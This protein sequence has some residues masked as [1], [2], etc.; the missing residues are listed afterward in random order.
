MGFTYNLTSAASIFVSY[1]KNLSV[2]GTDAL[3]GS[4]F[5]GTSPEPETSDSFDAG[6]RYQA[7]TIQAQIAGFYNRYNNRLATAYDPVADLT[8]T[9]NLG[10]VDKYGVDGSI[11]WQPTQ[12][13]L[14]YVFGSY[15]KSEIKDDIQ[16]GANSFAPTAGKREAG[17][18]EFTFGGRVQ[19]TLGPLEIG[20]QVKRT[21]PR[22][23][24]D[25]NT[26]EL[27]GYT[28]ADADV[29]LSLGYF[30]QD[31]DKAYFQVNVTNV[32][33][34]V[35]IGSAPTGLTTSGEFV[36]IGSP[37]AFTASLIWGF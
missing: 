32:F 4:L 24:N 26:I 5:A 35:Y 2:P 10:Q 1:A 23:L 30:N 13:L 33:D 12:P 37:R 27:P 17:A 21:G 7:G 19:G 6:A 15:L 11:A 16:I 25:I 8:V 14:L 3:Y 29:R 18:P 28:V 22:F 34:E 31:L 20:A 36:N 9:R